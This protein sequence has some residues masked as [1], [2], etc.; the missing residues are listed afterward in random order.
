MVT[1]EHYRDRNGCRYG[2][3][4]EWTAFTDA[5]ALARLFLLAAIAGA[6][7]L[8]AGVLASRADPSLRLDSRRKG[9]RRS[10]IAAGTDS[11]QAI[12]QVLPSGRSAL[13]T[14]WPKARLREFAW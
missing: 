6:V 8:L 10:L 4:L 9:P 2:I 13:R 1:E 14:L 5:A 3:K 11:P 12:A 7:W